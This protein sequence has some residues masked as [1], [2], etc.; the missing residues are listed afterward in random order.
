MRTSP[1]ALPIGNGKLAAMVYGGTSTEHL[2]FNEDTIWAGAPND[3]SNPGAGDWLETIQ[4]YIWEG[5]GEA[6]YNNAAKEN[7]MS[8]P[9]R[10]SPYVG[11][12]ILE[13]DFGH[14]GATD[15]R[16][17]LDLE[18]AKAI[19]TYT[20]DGVDY[21]RETFASY[22]DKVIVMRLTA[23]EG[24]SISFDL[25]YDSPHVDRT[26]SIDGNDFIM[27]ANVNQDADSR[28]QQTSAIEFQARARVLA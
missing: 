5:E 9:L 13:M 8:V 7:F 6:A 22:P 15:Y 18:T 21:R 12:G 26:V 11:A 4:N 28:R 27:D 24:G 19:I 1:E 3:Y 14:T 10:Q 25:S 23:S 16:R 17:T 2:Q 20:H